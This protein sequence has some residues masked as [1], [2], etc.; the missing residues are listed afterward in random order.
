VRI[1]VVLDL[2]DRCPERTHLASLLRWVERQAIK[3]GADAII[4]LPMLGEAE[5]RPYRARGY[6][7]VPETYTLLYRSTSSRCRAEQM[8]NPEAW[9]FCFAEHDAF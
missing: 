5:R 2:V 9:R 7:T 8:Q 1:G 3:A 6:W 4:A